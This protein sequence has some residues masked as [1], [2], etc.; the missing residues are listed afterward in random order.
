MIPLWLE[1][2]DCWPSRGRGARSGRLWPRHTRSVLVRRGFLLGCHKL[3]RASQ[4]LLGL[5]SPQNLIQQRAICGKGQH[6]RKVMPTAKPSTT[7]FSP[8]FGGRFRAAAKSS[9][10]APDSLA[11]L[12]LVWCMWGLMP[13]PG[14]VRSG[15]APVERPQRLPAE[16]HGRTQREVPRVR[17]P[18]PLHRDRLLR[19]SSRTPHGSQT[20]TCS[21]CPTCTGRCP[22][23]G[24]DPSWACVGGSPAVSL[25]SPG[26][27][28]RRPSGLRKRADDCRRAKRVARLRL[29]RAACV[30]PELPAGGGEAEVPPP[31][32]RAARPRHRALTRPAAVC[33]ETQRC[34]RRAAPGAQRVKQ[35]VRRPG[36]R[37]R[38]CRPPSCA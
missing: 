30:R 31:P 15:C 37:P 18:G 24:T 1:I 34:L 20:P 21:S 3:G 36:F 29:L 14:L 11:N 35:S 32:G 19:V 26:L 22:S 25:G 33:N 8:D 23:C 5:R 17:V 16:L 27:L 38:I 13:R 9:S 2:F 6:P 10:V 4:T 28:G 7:S 12:G